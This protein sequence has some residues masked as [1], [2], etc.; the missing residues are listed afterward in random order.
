MKFLYINIKQ[1]M[2]F[3]P[4]LKYL[5]KEK[6]FFLV[7]LLFLFF[8]SAL[9]LTPPAQSSGKRQNKEIFLSNLKDKKYSIELLLQWESIEQGIDLQNI[10]L[11]NQS[12][13]IEVRLRLYRF[14]P[15]LFNIRVLCG[16][17]YGHQR[18]DVK[19]LA[20][21]SGAVA[22][23]NS[24]YFDTRGNPL[25]YLKCNGKVINSK[26]ASHSLYSGV[27]FVR[28]GR[29]YIVHS[30][31]FDPG[32]DVSEAV[33]AGPRLI[34]KGK[35]TVGLKNANVIHHRSGIAIDR[36]GNI[37]IYATDSRYGGI[38]WNTLRHIL[39]LKKIGVH[40]VLNLDGGGSTQMYISTKNHEYYIRG[41]N[42]VP[43]AIAFFRK[44]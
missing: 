35:S 24:S 26:V 34:S 38:G 41:L 17:S 5:G 27:F 21:L 36:K 44:K 14:N 40:E 3:K 30:S 33:Q 29:P 13:G 6:E 37:I 10:N 16:K 43:S 25:A 23:I 22:I 39:K 12:G 7:L 4:I 19:T 11:F 42:P 20:N 31:R 2:C 32:I 28:H 9:I 1:I 18:T 8:F 15:A